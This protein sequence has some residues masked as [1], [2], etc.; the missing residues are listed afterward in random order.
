MKS[1]KNIPKNTTLDII[2]YVNKNL[3]LNKFTDV[4]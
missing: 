3:D 2:N 4:R 1:F